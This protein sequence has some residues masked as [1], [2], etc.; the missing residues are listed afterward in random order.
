MVV[1]LQPFVSERDN[2]RICTDAVRHPTRC[3]VRPSVLRLCSSGQLDLGTPP[4]LLTWFNVVKPHVYGNLAHAHAV[5]IR[6]SLRII[7]GLG[8]RLYQEYIIEREGE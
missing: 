1:N 5:D 3:P 6:P 4:S 8:T 7:E 2:I